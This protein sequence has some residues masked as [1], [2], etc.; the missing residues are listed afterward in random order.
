MADLTYYK[1]EIGDKGIRYFLSARILKICDICMFL[2]TKLF[3]GRKTFKFNTNSYRY[4]ISKYNFAWK[5]ERTIEVPIAFAEINKY[6]SSEILEVGNVLSHYYDIKHDILDKYEKS[7]NVINKDIATFKTK[8]KYKLIV[9]ISTL[10]HVG[11]EEKPKDPLKILKAIEN[12][13]KILSTEGEILITLPVGYH[14][15]K[16]NNL[17]N[18][19]ALG[20]NETYY[21]KR[22][23]ADNKW[24]QST[25]EKVKNHKYNSAFPNANAI[26][27]GLIRP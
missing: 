11:W 7:N 26:L 14:N 5:N 19:S 23:S 1:E 16:L 18:T 17:I 8:K 20:L 24:E 27:I 3:K 10:E 21:M 6:D 4:L 12:M 9:A 25:L 22:I 15:P 2:V 13:K